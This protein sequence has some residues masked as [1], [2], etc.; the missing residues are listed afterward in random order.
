MNRKQP[1]HSSFFV[2]K[3]KIIYNRAGFLN[4]PR[5]ENIFYYETS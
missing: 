1:G 4:I 5:N 2:G 3:E